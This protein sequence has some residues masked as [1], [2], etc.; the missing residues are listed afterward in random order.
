[1]FY[2]SRGIEL[3]L[4]PRWCLFFVIC[5]SNSVRI[6]M[7]KHCIVIVSTYEHVHLLFCAHFISIFSILGCLLCVICKSN[8]FQHFSLLYIQTLH[9]ECSHIE[10]VHHL[11]C[12]H[13]ILF[14][15]IFV[16][17]ELRYYYVYTTFRML[18]LC[19]II[20]KVFIPFVLPEKHNGHIGI[21]W[22]PID[23]F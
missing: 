10:D 23:N 9:N 6:L 4:H 15:S 17:V 7:F 5:N 18:T 12:A 14:Y 16:S 20:I 21:M 3:V 8:S 2:I 13:L 11:F 1:M 22:F 19:N